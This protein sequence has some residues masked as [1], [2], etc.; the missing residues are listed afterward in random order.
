MVSFKEQPILQIHE[1]AKDGDYDRL[2]QLLD[3]GFP[4][5]TFDERGMTPLAYACQS[6]RASL[7]I[8]QLLVNSGANPNRADLRDSSYPI[9]LAAAAG[10]IPKVEFLLDADA[11]VR[12]ESKGKYTIMVHCIYGLYDSD[13]LLP[14]I[15]F[16]HEKG[17]SLGTESEYGESPLSVASGF[18]RFDAVKCLLERGADETALGWNDLMKALIFGGNE[19]FQLELDR[20]RQIHH[21]D[22]WGRSAW[23]L[24]AFGPYLEKAKMLHERGID[25]ETTARGGSTALMLCAVRGNIDMLRWLISIGANIEAEDESGATALRAA[26][27]SSQVEC[28]AILLE[29]GANPRHEDEYGGKAIS[30]ASHA[31]IIRMLEDA[32]EDISD[33]STESKRQLVGL[34]E[35]DRIDCTDEDF[36]AAY[37]PRFGVSNPEQM[38]VP[39]WEAMVRCGCHAHRARIQFDP[40]DKRSSPLW[41]FDRFGISFTKLPDGRFVQIGGEHEDYYDPDFYIYNDVIVHTAKGKFKIYGYPKNVFPPTDFHSA[42][43]VD[44]FIYLIGGLGY[45]GKRRFGETPV[46]RLSIKDWSMHAVET[47]GDHPGWI[48]Q[49]RCRLF[50]EARLLV[51]G[52]KICRK[53]KG[54]EVH[55][56]NTSEYE[57]DL[58]SR[59]WTWKS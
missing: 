20:T 48:Y 54:K 17:A 36:Q 8:L 23:H 29:A 22:R 42:T 49:H 2:Q 40:N 11:N 12:Y 47:S 21:R 10:S 35:Q 39:F 16:L 43:L 15:Q 9:G 45:A 53:K 13:K 41:C 56:E 6:P 34:A 27:R 31:T 4:V 32:G 26:V 57:L 28:L 3:S 33:L 51:S 1:A 18:A 5:D 55:E 24:A 14:M 44:E 37:N 52:G 19:Q 46:Y 50:D 7:G 58:R 59:E 25:V 38:N 30:E